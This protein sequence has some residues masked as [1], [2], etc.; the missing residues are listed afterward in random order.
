MPNFEKIQELAD[1]MRRLPPEN[2]KMHRLLFINRP[3]ETVAEAAN[4]GCGTVGCIAGHGAVYFYYKRELILKQS[5]IPSIIANYTMDVEAHAC[6]FEPTAVTQKALNLSSD[7]A[8]YMFFAGWF[9]PGSS[10]MYLHDMQAIP[11]GD[12]VRY[13]DKVVA[14]KDVF[15]KLNA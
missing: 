6:D 1:H 4:P 7:E 8:D 9:R 11:G 15:V 3:Q 13:L 12:V 5:G 2:I 10:R 14:E